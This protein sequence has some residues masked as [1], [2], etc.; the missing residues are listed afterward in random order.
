MGSP[1]PSK[2]RNAAVF[3]VA[4]TELFVLLLFLVI[5]LWIATAP[6]QLIPRDVPYDVL[7]Q[8]LSNLKKQLEETLRK[9]IDLQGMVR[10][11][12][13]QLKLLWELYKKKPITLTPGTPQWEKWLEDWRL[14]LE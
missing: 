11:R 10:Q 12:D 1:S 2:Q 9:L 5:F 3:G 13:A 8:Q 7:S 14:E 4:L 6:K